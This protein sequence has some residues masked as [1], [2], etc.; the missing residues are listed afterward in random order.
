MKLIAHTK[1]SQ[2]KQQDLVEHFNRGILCDIKN[3]MIIDVG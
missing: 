3:I 2:G 1:N